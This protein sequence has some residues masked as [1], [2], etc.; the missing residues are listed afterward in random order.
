METTGRID[1]D[2]VYIHGRV[3]RSVE[4]AA[5]RY[6]FPERLNHSSYVQSREY[7]SGASCPDLVW[8]F[9]IR[10]FRCGTPYVP[11]AS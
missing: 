10:G 4:C 11:T 2:L 7:G 6:A 8:G 1:I 5:I 9:L 3:G